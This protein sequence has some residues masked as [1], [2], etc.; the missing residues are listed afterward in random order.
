M[1]RYITGSGIDVR[2]KAN[3]CHI[4]KSIESAIDVFNMK[5]D[6]DVKPVKSKKTKKPVKIC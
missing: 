1:G 3:G 6:D 2:G 4:E 5:F